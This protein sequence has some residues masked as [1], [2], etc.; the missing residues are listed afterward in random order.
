MHLAL[1]LSLNI[2]VFCAKLCKRAL[3]TF[4]QIIFL[5]TLDS[6]HCHGTC[7]FYQLRVS[8]LLFQNLIKLSSDLA[9]Q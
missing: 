9:Q 2:Y 4:E 8:F 1:Q 6:C 7:L 5:N 3:L